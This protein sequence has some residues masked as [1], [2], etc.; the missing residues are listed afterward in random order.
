M[1]N[2][3]FILAGLFITANTMGQC[4]QVN[5]GVVIEQ[6]V[7]PCKGPVI[8]DANVPDATYL[9]STGETTKQI[10]VTRTDTLT[11]IVDKAGC[12]GVDTVSV[13]FLESPIVYLGADPLPR[14]GGC[15]TLDVG[16]QGGAQI[17]WSTGDSSQ[18]VNFCDI[19]INKVWATVTND[20]GCSVSDT[21]EVSV[22]PGYGIDLG[23]SDTVV[24]A[25]SITI[26]PHSSF[27]GTYKWSNGESDTS[28]VVKQSGVYYIDIF[29]IPGCSPSDTI[30]DSISIKLSSSPIVDLGPDPDIKCG[31]CVLLDAGSFSDA[32][33]W[34]STG[35]TTSSILY[36]KTGFTS[37][38]AQVTTSEGCFDIDTI[39]INIKEGY[40]PSLG[41]D[42][43]LCG[44]SLIIRS[45]DIG[46][47]I[48]WNTGETSD[49][50]IVKSSGIYYVSITDIPGCNPADTTSDTISVTLNK[51]PIVSLGP[52]PDKKCTGCFSLDA[53][54]LAGGTYQW[55]TGE[56]SQQIS[57]CKTGENNVWAK[58]TDSNLCSA[59]D[60]IILFI[61]DDL[62]AILGKD[63]T[64]CGQEVT[65]KSPVLQGDYVWSTGETTPEITVYES[66]FYTVKVFNV[67]GCLPEDTLT[68]TLEVSFVQVLAN[69]T[70]IIDLSSACG[71]L[72]YMINPVP[73]ASSYEWKVPDG[74]KILSG[75]GTNLVELESNEM[76]QGTITVKASNS[77]ANCASGE[78][79]IES[80][81]TIYSVHVPNTFS[82]NSDG[83]ND[84]WILRNIEYFPDNELV[85]LNRWGNEV[86]KKRGYRN[87]WDG[88]SLNEG[89]YYFKLKIRFCNTEKTIVNYLTIVR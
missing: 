52:D 89:T 37:V 71:K 8:L 54:V 17:K 63:T 66:G 5:V 41:E 12:I 42:L 18:V 53:G 23:S 79:S 34:W 72:E 15:V 67:N 39:R 40:N 20:L 14:C 65:L 75:Q 73:G 24:C 85:V 82:P 88:S 43:T 25:D 68:D 50:I 83:I 3:L 11:I 47:K 29:N 22:K 44:D 1:K 84:L 9:W 61:R 77:M 30:S 81:E 74:W 26:S 70:L 38:C 28:I 57:Y 64:L 59:S 58:V 2:L 36:C 55:S 7:D 86:Y 87:T 13:L 21:I 49:S 76:K 31:G 33:Y 78:A 32:K 69:P 6:E 56:T 35:D 60:T 16:D 62:G 4:L 80:N 46:R 10:T 45:A 48:I 51:L 19:G 27:G